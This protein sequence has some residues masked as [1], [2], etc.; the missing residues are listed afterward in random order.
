MAAANATAVRDAAAPAAAAEGPFA[1]LVEA[2]SALRKAHTHTPNP[3]PEPAPAGGD[4]AA[5]LE[6]AAEA[7]NAAGDRPGNGLGR[8]LAQAAESL[9]A[10]HRHRGPVALGG[11]MTTALELAEARGGSVAVSDAPAELGLALRRRLAR[12]GSVAAAG[13]N[14]DC[15]RVQRCVPLPSTH[16]EEIE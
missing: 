12:A 11:T 7:L 14:G 6:E 9:D 16:K 13:F 2:A 5:V 10:E 3:P 4:Y 8:L 1:T 15:L